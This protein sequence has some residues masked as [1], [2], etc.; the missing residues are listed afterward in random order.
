MQH[1]LESSEI[2]VRNINNALMD[3]AS[4]VDIKE[5]GRIDWERYPLRKSRF[6]IE[7]GENEIE[8]KKINHTFPTPDSIVEVILH[9]DHK[10]YYSENSE[11]YS[12]FLL[13]PALHRDTRK[14]VQE[15]FRERYSLELSVR[16]AHK[17]WITEDGIPYIAVNA[18]IQKGKHIFSTYTKQGRIFAK[19]EISV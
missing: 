17:K 11:I 9:K 5:K 3:F 13:L 18:Q 7:H 12:P 2:T 10:E 8:I 16:P 14:Y 6:F 15:T 4:L 1:S 19:K